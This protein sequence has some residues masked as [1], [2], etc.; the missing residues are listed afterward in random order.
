MCR[1]L[2]IWTFLLA[3][4]WIQSQLAL[5]F[6]AWP[7]LAAETSFRVWPKIGPARCWTRFQNIGPGSGKYYIAQPLLPSRAPEPLRWRAIAPLAATDLRKPSGEARVGIG[8][9]RGWRSATRATSCSAARAG[10]SYP[11]TRS[12]SPTARF[13]A[14]IAPLKVPPPRC[15]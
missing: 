4:A 3:Q 15:L 7:N 5:D 8:G 14:S 6:Q 11:S 13:V 1:G 9:D 10:P 12:S 2:G